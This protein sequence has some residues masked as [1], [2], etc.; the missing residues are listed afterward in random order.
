MNIENKKQLAIILFAAGLGIMA[1]LLTGQY[2]QN[3]I[4]EESK[5]R[6][7]IFEEQQMK[8]LKMEVDQMR[9][10]M[11]A[12][13]SRPVAAAGGAEGV[14]KGPA[15]SLSVMTPAGKRAYTVRIDPLSAVGGMINP[16][17]YVDILAHMNMPDPISNKSERITSVIF[18]NVK[19]LAVGTNLQAIGGY[20]QQQ[21]AGALNITFALSPEEA[22]LMSFIE[23][24]GQMQ[25]ILRPSAETQIET[26]QKA[27]WQ[28]LAEYV[29]QK[30]GTEISSPLSRSPLKPVD[31]KGAEIKNYIEIFKGGQQQ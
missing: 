17:D 25:L 3:S 15:S 22:S 7:K 9:Q 28:N 21:A 8:P 4:Q 31:D 16:T 2:I 18:Q 13:A 12:L 26:L 23:K 24:N 1:A 19:V 5:K 27:D 29:F 11:A 20:D 14:G 30:Q 10:Q 6:A